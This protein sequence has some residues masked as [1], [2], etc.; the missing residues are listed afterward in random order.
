MPPMPHGSADMLV[1]THDG[2]QTWSGVQTNNLLFGV[3]NTPIVLVDAQTAW[4]V[5][6]TTAGGWIYRTTDGGVNWAQNTW[7]P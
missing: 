5:Q 2:G 4:Y 7:Q 1:Q 3:Q 6:E